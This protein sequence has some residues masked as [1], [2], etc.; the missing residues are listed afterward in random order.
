VSYS[1]SWNARAECR[2]DC[3]FV[4]RDGG[5]PIGDFRKAWRTACVAAGLNT[6]L[7]HDLRCT[8]MRNM[9]HA[10]VSDRVAMALSGHKTRSIFDRYN[11]VSESD[12]VAASERLQAHLGAQATEPKVGPLKHRG[13]TASARHHNDLA[14][15]PTCAGE[16]TSEALNKALNRVPECSHC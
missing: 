5:Q 2:P 4:F 14:P 12:L 13:R 15:S 3:Q 16:L 8:A 9:V 11:T 6:I 7:V 10:G 1:E